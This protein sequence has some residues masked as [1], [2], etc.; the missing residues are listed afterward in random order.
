VAKEK[1]ALSVWW[2]EMIE[3]AL[4]RLLKNSSYVKTD[5]PKEHEALLANGWEEIA[6]D[7]STGWLMRKDKPP[8]ATATPEVKGGKL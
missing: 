7:E 2:G 6:G 1:N 8:A 4:A 5:D 3:Q